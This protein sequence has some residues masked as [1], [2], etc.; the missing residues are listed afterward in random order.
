MALNNHTT[1]KGLTALQLLPPIDSA[2]LNAHELFVRVLG[3]EVRHGL[4]LGDPRVPHDRVLEV[5]AR[6][7]E[8]RLAVLQHGGGVLLDGLV[9][10]VGLAGDAKRRVGLRVLGGVEDFVRVGC[11][12]EA[13]DLEFGDVLLREAVLEGTVHDG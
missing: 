6:D 9:D 2:D 3:P 11:G 10:A 5:V 7:V 13:V 1:L 4:G 12:A 8:Q